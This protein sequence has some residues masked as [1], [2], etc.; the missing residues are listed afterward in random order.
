MG[1]IANIVAFDGASTPVSHTLVP[2]S[3]TREKN[4]ITASWREASSGVP[5]YAQVRVS[6]TLERL[7]SG[8]YKVENRVEVPV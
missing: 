8:V 3:V 2:V 1:Q 4:K 5:V 7:K 6:M